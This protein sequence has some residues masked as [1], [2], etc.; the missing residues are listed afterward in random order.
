MGKQSQR[1]VG[2]E[3]AGEVVMGLRESF[4]SGKTRSYEWRAAQLKGIIRMIDE[5]EENIMEALEADL[6]KPKLESFV[7]ED[8]LGE[9]FMWIGFKGIEA[10][11]ET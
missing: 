9:V 6:S 11:D 1:P 4:A 3:S 10:L 7:H 5:K 8:F 2:E